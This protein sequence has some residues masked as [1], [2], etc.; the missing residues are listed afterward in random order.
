MTVFKLIFF[1]HKA[2]NDS[3]EGPSKSI[4]RIL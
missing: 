3:N 2:N 4:T 1:E